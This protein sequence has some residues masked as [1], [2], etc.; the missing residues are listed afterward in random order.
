MTGSSRKRL[1]KYL[2]GIAADITRLRLEVAVAKNDAADIL[3]EIQRL[4]ASDPE[5]ASNDPEGTGLIRDEIY[6]A[7]AKERQV[8]GLKQGDKAPVD[9]H[10]DQ[11]GSK[12][13]YARRNDILAKEAEAPGTPYR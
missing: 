9:L 5:T 4:W 1:F 2:H 6:K 12:T 8:S 10:G 13:D 3:E 7:Q 11:R